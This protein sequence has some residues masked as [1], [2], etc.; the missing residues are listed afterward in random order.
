MKSYLRSFSVFVLA[1]AFVTVQAQQNH[2]IYLQTEN[3][4]PFYVKMGKTIYNSTVSGYLIIPKLKEGN[5]DFSVGF[6][7]KEYGE[8]KFSTTVARQDIGYIVKQF[9]DKGWGL[10]NLQT[11]QVTM[12]GA[13]ETYPDPAKNTTVK[14]DD[15]SQMLST[16]VNDPAIKYE[17]K[18]QMPEKR[19]NNDTPASR[20]PVV[21]AAVQASKDE[22]VKK[23]ED[24][25][26]AVTKDVA[27]INKPA[28]KA[29]IVKA[30]AVMGKDGLNMIYI[31]SGY[32]GKVDTITVLIPVEEE[33]KADTAKAIPVT[34]AT[35]LD[36]KKE[37]EPTAV[38]KTAN[39]KEEEAG[40]TTIKEEPQ[41][42]KPDANKV[43]KQDKKFLNIDISSDEP[44]KNDSAQIP[45]KL[46]NSSVTGLIVSNNSSCGA[47]S[48]ESDF[49]KLRKKMAAADSEDDMINL[50]KKAFKTKCYSTD[51]VK[52]LG[53]LFLND[54]GRY[55]F[56]DIAYPHVYDTNNFSQLLNQLVDE[57]YKN[58]FKAMLRQ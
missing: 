40:K 46:N 51:Q 58:R 50:A 38:A 20:P 6:V 25:S 23:K 4:Q 33:I 22:E 43:T 32:A 37:P 16:V 31:D 21:S 54:A 2:F 53:F 15:F 3:K 19:A 9:G 13:R 39:S 5:Y 10:F 44:A 57:Y 30:A 14:T 47:Y 17:K 18:D 49:L 48:N 52:N 7:S 35:A 1:F 34:S 26:N 24:D 27:L 12:A 45:D 41:K 29:N 42:G 56:F 36:G 55:N 11:L 28:R 8:Q